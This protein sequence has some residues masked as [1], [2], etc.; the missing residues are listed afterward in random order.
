ML[1]FP[2]DYKRANTFLTLSL[3]G[4]ISFRTSQLFYQSIFGI[5]YDNFYQKFINILLWTQL[6]FLLNI[7]CRYKFIKFCRLV[8]LSW[9]YVLL[10]LFILYPHPSLWGLVRLG[11]NLD[12][13]LHKKLRALNR[14]FRPIFLGFFIHN[15]S[16]DESFELLN[17]FVI[18]LY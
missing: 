1:M 15:L 11:S 4:V 13:L 18:Y 2:M 3:C 12:L 10:S 5:T 7:T 6:L 14:I 16:E 9:I 17:Y 8:W